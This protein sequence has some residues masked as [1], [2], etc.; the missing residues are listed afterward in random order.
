[1]KEKIMSSCVSFFSSKKKKTYKS[2]KLSQ[3]EKKKK[4]KIRRKIKIILINIWLNY[5]F[6]SC[7]G[8]KMLN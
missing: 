6:D 1:M 4:K 8:L 2:E 5:S 7:F 3:I